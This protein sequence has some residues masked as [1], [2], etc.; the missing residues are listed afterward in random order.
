MIEL[1]SS[2]N[3]IKSIHKIQSSAFFHEQKNHLQGELKKD[4]FRTQF[5]LRGFN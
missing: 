3:K 4:P 5:C 1:M 2:N